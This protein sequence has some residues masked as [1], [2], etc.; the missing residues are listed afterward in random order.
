MSQTSITPSLPEEAQR[1]WPTPARPLALNGVIETAPP[2]A[3]GS[4]RS[5]SQPDSARSLMVEDTSEY[6]R[7]VGAISK[8]AGYQ[9]CSAKTGTLGLEI[10]AK[11]PAEPDPARHP[12]ARD[13]QLRGLPSARA[14]GAWPGETARPQRRR[15]GVVDVRRGLM[16]ELR[17]VKLKFQS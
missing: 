3:L 16:P 15:D 1:N 9:P 5:M 14:R 7:V 12:H 2:P 13:R 8:Q 6:I 10:A 17:N 4:R 11:N